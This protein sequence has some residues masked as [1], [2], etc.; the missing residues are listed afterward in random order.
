MNESPKELEIEESRLDTL[1]EVKTEIKTLVFKNAIGL[2]VDGSQM[3]E[4]LASIPGIEA[5]T[6]VVVASSSRLRD[7]AIVRGLPRL[8]NIQVNGAHIQS[9]DGLAWFRNGRYLNIDTGKNRRRTIAGIGDAPI[10]KLSLQYAKAQD[11]EAIAESSTLS[12]L[13][14]GA[15][16]QPPFER[17][18]H[19]PVSALV[20]SNGSF[21][22]ITDTAILA[23]L[24]KLVL[25]R[26]RRLEELTGDNSNVTWLVIQGCRRLRLHTVATFPNL[27]SLF[28][29]GDQ[30]KVALSHLGQMARLATLSFE[31]CKVT[32]DIP[33]LGA[34]MPRLA[35]LHIAGLGEDQALHLSRANPE[36]SVSNGTH[37]YRNGVA[38][39]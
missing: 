14:L 6:S 1:R 2:D 7:L 30:S 26:C 35:S 34:S 28:I 33:E 36:I 27:E 23:T 37:V 29:V 17:W 5:I 32:I 19:V 11:F 18:E 25:T 22:E 16:P 8:L 9:L 3:A 13:E 39:M 15:S 12:H 4:H 20:F 10:T 24:K 38:S 31:N 21:Q